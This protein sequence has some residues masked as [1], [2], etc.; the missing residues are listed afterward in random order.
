MKSGKEINEE[1]AKYMEHFRN[2][3]GISL[4]QLANE[5]KLTAGFLSR[6]NNGKRKAPTLEKV[7]DIAEVLDMP[8]SPL[9]NDLQ[10]SQNIL[11]IYDLI[12][13]NEFTVGGTKV[14]TGAKE[15]II[16]ILKGNISVIE[17]EVEK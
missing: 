17:G 5:S 3:K 11:D 7:Y 10:E 1:F 6:L 14:D 2:K 12:L 4:T 13:L 15:T 9:F 8:L 16:N